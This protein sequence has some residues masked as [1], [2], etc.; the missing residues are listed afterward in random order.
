MPLKVIKGRLED[1]TSG[2]DDL[3]VREARGGY[4]SGHPWRGRKRPARDGCGSPWCRS[5]R[6]PR[7][8]EPV[9]RTRPRSASSRGSTIDRPRLAGREAA[10][11][12]PGFDHPEAAEPRGVTETGHERGPSPWV[13]PPAHLQASSPG[14][15]P[16]SG[17][18]RASRFPAGP[19]QG[20]GLHAAGSGLPT[21]IARRADRSDCHHLRHGRRPAGA[22][23]TGKVGTPVRGACTGGRSWRGS[24][25][26]TQRR[27]DRQ[28]QPRPG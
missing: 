4:R 28:G 16:R 13:P 10:G 11:K 20:R 27:R 22:S 8:P 25:R 3:R 6:R 12:L 5:A 18:Q 7:P 15:A 17:D 23:R 2:G 14:Q 26:S 24:F 9:R 19:S 1:E 21:G